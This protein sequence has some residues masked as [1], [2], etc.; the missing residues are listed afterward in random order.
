MAAIVDIY[1]RVSTDPQED[2]TSL[3]EQENAGRRYAHENGLIVGLVHREVLSGYQYRERA[4]LGLMR[5][6]YREGKIK[7]SLSAPLTAS[8]D[9]RCITP[10]SWKRWST[11]TSRCIASKRRST[12]LRWEGLPG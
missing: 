4:K 11:T 8:H 10:S 6:R 12:I 7:A 5:E 3:D 2:N 9:P 1:C